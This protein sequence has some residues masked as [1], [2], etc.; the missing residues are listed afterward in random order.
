MSHI[1]SRLKQV[2]SRAGRTL[3]RS[4]NRYLAVHPSPKLHLG[5]GGNILPGWLNTDLA[6]RSLEVAFLDATRP[7][8]FDDATF[9]FVYTEHMIEHLSYDQGFH[10]LA[11]SYRVLRPGGRIR[12]ATPDIRFLIDLYRA[13]PSALQR[14]YVEWSTQTFNPGAPFPH[15]TFVVNTFFRSWGHAFIYDESILRDALKRTGFRGVTCCSLGQS[16]A[17]ALRNLELTERLP[18][19][20]LELE[21]MIL[22]GVKE[23]GFPTEE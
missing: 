12:V 3:T 19:R 9:D 16:E 17:P 23:S 15:A 1:Y 18:S 11:E 14:A 4:T 2:W 10:L 6:P 21:T 22:E 20:F 13:E 8:P 5:C 7:F